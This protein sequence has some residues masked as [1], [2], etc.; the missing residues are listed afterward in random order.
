MPFQID[1]FADTDM[2]TMATLLKARAK[3]FS[4]S[5]SDPNARHE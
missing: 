4:I 3:N 5:V 2:E 1:G